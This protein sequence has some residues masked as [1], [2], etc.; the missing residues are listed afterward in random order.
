M[1]V[2]APADENECRQ[3]LTTGFLHQG[4]ATVRYPRGKGPGVTVEPGLTALPIGK[5]E[6]RQQGA[7]VAILAWGSLVTPCESV[8]QQLGATLVNM[9]FI[10]PL[11]EA[12]LLELASSYKLLV[13]VEE[14]VIAGGAGSAVSEFLQAQGITLP[15]LQI[16]LPDRFVE[17]G[18]R[19]QLLALCGLDA[20]GI[21]KTI[22]QR[23]G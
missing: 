15:L 21:L 18:S 6:L 13:T 1:L 4:P 8:A 9:R 19:E 2:M 16:G 3:M 23:L 17:Q 10:K 11:D 5:A 7:E 20:E 14:N 12:L 22:K